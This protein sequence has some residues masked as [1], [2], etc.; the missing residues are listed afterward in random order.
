M[1]FQIKAANLRCDCPRAIS[2]VF[3]SMYF[4][5]HLLLR[6]FPDPKQTGRGYYVYMYMHKKKTVNMALERVHQILRD[7][8]K[9]TTQSAQQIGSEEV[10]VDELKTSVQI[11][12]SLQLDSSQWS[13]EKVA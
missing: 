4:R 12:T 8:G 6:W 9:G 7:A 3:C 10:G 1:K 11:K 5:D 2:Y 13:L